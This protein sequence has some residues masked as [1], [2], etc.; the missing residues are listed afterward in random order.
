MSWLIVISL[1]IV[2]AV[3]WRIQLGASPE[4]VE[5][6]KMEIE[7][8]RRDFAS[9]K[10]LTKCGLHKR[11]YAYMDKYDHQ[12]SLKSRCSIGFHLEAPGG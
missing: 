2:T 4:N 8:L 6:A 10:L 11:L 9:G 5:A 7:A 3:A 12:T 1:G